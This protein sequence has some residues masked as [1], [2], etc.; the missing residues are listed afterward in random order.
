[1]DLSFSNKLQNLNDNELYTTNGGEPITVCII[2]GIAII[3]VVVVAAWKA[4]ETQAKNEIRS[5]KW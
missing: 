5:G 3:A 2:A 1:M 4:G